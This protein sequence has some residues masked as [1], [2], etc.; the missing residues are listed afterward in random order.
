MNLQACGT[1]GGT[2]KRGRPQQT[3]TCRCV[4]QAERWMH[5][6]R[7]DQGQAT[8]QRDGEEENSGTTVS[9]EADIWKVLG[10]AASTLLRYDRAQHKGPEGEAR[11]RKK[12]DGWAAAWHARW[13]V[14]VRGPPTRSRRQ[15][16]SGEQD[17]VV[18]RHALQVL[19]ALRSRNQFGWLVAQVAMGKTWKKRTVAAYHW[20]QVNWAAQVILASYNATNHDQSAYLPQ[21]VRRLLQGTILVRPTTS[22]IPQDGD[23]GSTGAWIYALRT[24]N[25]RRTY[26]GA[27]DR[28]SQGTA[29]ESSPGERHWEHLRTGWWRAQGHRQG[30]RAMI[31]LYKMNARWQY[32][33]SELTM[34]PIIALG[35]KKQADPEATASTGSNKNRNR[36]TGTT[37]TIRSKLLGLEAAMQRRWKPGYVAAWAGRRRHTS[38]AA[39]MGNLTDWGADQDDDAGEA[40]RAVSGP[41]RGLRL[42]VSFGSLSGLKCLARSLEIPWSV[43]VI[44]KCEV[45]RP[46][47]AVGTGTDNLIN[48]TKIS[49][50][51]LDYN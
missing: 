16:E 32:G 11:G 29:R 22:A 28:K 44:R 33:L 13:I 46:W 23:A 3:K 19:N 39:R 40:D 38:N 42:A 34:I 41:R 43:S 25:G 27:T 20:Q 36:R 30:S 24:M 12:W 48:W 10:T 14:Q 47:G 5:N 1:W 21:E 8:E 9:C 18:L 31:P 51:Q 2:R 50:L 37:T 15:G 4:A 49:Q 6:V 45:L 17:K 35:E 26:I 7:P